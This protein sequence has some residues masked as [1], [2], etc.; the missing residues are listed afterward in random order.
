MSKPAL[1]C[2]RVSSKEFGNSKLG[3]TF[4]TIYNYQVLTIWTHLGDASDCY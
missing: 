4:Y 2:W 1:V 3:F